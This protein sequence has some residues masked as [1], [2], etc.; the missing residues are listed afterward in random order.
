MLE[1]KT[2]HHYHPQLPKI[3]VTEEEL[4]ELITFIDGLD[5]SYGDL[6]IQ[7]LR[8][9][10]MDAFVAL[11]VVQLFNLTCLRIGHNFAKESQYLGKVLRSA[12]CEPG[13]FALPKFEH[14]I[15]VS[16]NIM[17]ELSR[18]KNARNTA[19]VLAFFYLPA[20][21]RISASIDNP[22]TFTWPATHKP[23]PQSLISLDLNTIR[24]D[25]LGEILSV[26][27]GLKTLRWK[28]YHRDSFRDRSDASQV[29][30]DRY[31][32]PVIDLSQIAEALSHLRYTLT[33]LTISAACHMSN[34]DLAPPALT[35]AG[36]L[37]KLTQLA[38][39]KNLTLPLPF[40]VGFSPEE[41]RLLG[42]V[43]P[44]H[45]E[46]FIIRNDLVLQEENEMDAVTVFGAVKLWL[47]SIQESMPSRQGMTLALKSLDEEDWSFDLRVSL[48][49]L[50]HA[51]GIK[52]ELD[53]SY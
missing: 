27:Q 24:E 33:D 53:F 14:L 6:W 25:S 47:E 5:M 13:S 9:G 41:P 19:N 48:T 16:F 29:I 8:R 40:L 17:T 4:G 11:L 10:T 51:L 30:N 15:D 46:S 3:P 39:L 12:L 31:G 22:V 23:N 1:G 38:K 50:C 49:E 43:I 26:T 34:A 52:V 18:P 44:T 2:F 20:V 45:I 7:D 28:W 35:I 37:D 21:Q 32:E 42:S 36:S